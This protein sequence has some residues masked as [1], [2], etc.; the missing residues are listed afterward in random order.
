MNIKSSKFCG[1]RVFCKTSKVIAIHFE[2]F[3]ALKCKAGKN[4]EIYINLAGRKG[5]GKS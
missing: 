5:E 2:P 4:S 1:E 3:A